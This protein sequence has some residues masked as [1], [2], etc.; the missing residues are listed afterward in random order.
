MPHILY[1]TST[2]HTET[3]AFYLRSGR[4]DGRSD[5]IQKNRLACDDSVARQWGETK[6]KCY[7]NNDTIIL[8]VIMKVWFMKKY[9]CYQKSVAVMNESIF[10]V[11]YS[12]TINYMILDCVEKR[13]ELQPLTLF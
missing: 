9:G 6:G 1:P 13:M 10:I 2:S 5:D 3:A 7:R 12:Q 11:F 4:S 8:G